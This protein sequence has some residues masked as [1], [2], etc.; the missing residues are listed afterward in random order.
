VPAKAADPLAFQGPLQ[1]RRDLRTLVARGR[2]QRVEV[3]PDQDLQRDPLPAVGVFLFLAQQK[4]C[5][6]GCVHL[7]APP[8]FSRPP[9]SGGLRGGG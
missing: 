9:V 8:V 2:Q 4:F 6:G 5:A 1:P 7:P 3:D